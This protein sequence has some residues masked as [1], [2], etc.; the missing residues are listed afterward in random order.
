MPDPEALNLESAFNSEGHVNTLSYNCPSM[1]FNAELAVSGG[2][3]AARALVDTGATHCYISQSFFERTGLPLRNDHT[4]LSLANGSKA[5]SKGKAVIPLDVQTYQGAVEC[6]ILPMSQHFDI[7]LGETWCVETGC[8]ISYKSHSL[9][10]VDTDGRRHKLL[11]QSTETSMLCPIISAVHL[12]DSLQHDDLL[13]LVNVTEGHDHVN[14]VQSEQLPNDSRLESLLEENKDRFPADL[15]AK[16]PPERNVYHT[17]P[18]KNNDPPPP[19]KSYRLSKP[20][21]EELNTQV[22]SLLEKGYIQPSNSPY[23]H[24]VL[25]V[26]KKNGNLRMCIDYRSLNQPTVK[27]SLLTTKSG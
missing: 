9:T 23:G 19:R 3:I 11:T 6:F 10:C 21:V 13:Y 16:L 26:K 25:F 27:S 15:P 12:E 4:W 1:M 20:E 5:V 17:I 7:I 8:E 24:P 2:H 22:A 18:L 14:A